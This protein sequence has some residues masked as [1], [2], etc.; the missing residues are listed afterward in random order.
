MMRL[1]DVVQGSLLYLFKVAGSGFPGTH[2]IINVC[3]I[4]ISGFVFCHWLLAH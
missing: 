1:R 2:R 3:S 4:F